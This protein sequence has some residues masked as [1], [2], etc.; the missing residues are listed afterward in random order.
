MLSA[1]EKAVLRLIARGES[2]E[3]IRRKVNLDDEGFRHCLDGLSGELGISDRLELMFLACSE[4][5]KLL[6]GEREAA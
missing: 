6:L 2:D 4:E 5:G 1:T 3:Q